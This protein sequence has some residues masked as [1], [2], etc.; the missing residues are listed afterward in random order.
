MQ[1]SS[2]FATSSFDLTTVHSL[3]P[4]LRKFTASDRPRHSRSTRRM[5]SSV[6]SS[7][8]REERGERDIDGDLRV[9]FRDNP[10]SWGADGHS[11][12]R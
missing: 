4:F 1:A 3:D 2:S 9:D 10:R 6:A 8:K 12:E 7:A 11:G 5:F